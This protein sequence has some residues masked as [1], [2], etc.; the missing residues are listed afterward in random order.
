M[1]QVLAR[2]WWVL[3]IR[4][5]VAILFG[6]MAII[7]PGL[8]LRVLLILIGAF[9]IVDGIFAGVAAVR[10][11]Q[12]RT[13]WW[14]LALEAVAGIITGLVVWIWP[15]LS[16]LALV[17]VIAAWAIITGV[18]ELIAAVRLRQQIA[19]EWLLALSGALSVLFGI[20]IAVYPRGGA[21]A[22][23]W[24]I[25]IYAILVGLLLVVLSFRLRSLQTAP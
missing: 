17:Y 12:Q 22:I 19:N 25:G 8:T 13:Q 15:G 14:P 2:Y 7:W 10:A 9:F 18:F 23:I 20:L 6:V 24:I 5:A 4:G 21:L 16:A 3:L 11:V 1:L